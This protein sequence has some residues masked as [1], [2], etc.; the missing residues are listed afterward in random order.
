MFLGLPL[1]VAR[2]ISVVRTL[3]Y[4]VAFRRGTSDKGV[5]EHSFENDIFLSGVP[6]YQPRNGDVVLDVGAHL[7]DFS[8]LVAREIGSGRV[9]ALEPCDETFRLLKLNIRL[10]KITNIRPQK[11]ALAD[12]DGTCML[13]QAPDGQDWG[14]STVYDYAFHSEEVKCLTLKTFMDELNIDQV[15]FA[16]FNCEGAEFSVLLDADPEVLRRF[17]TML[18]LYHSD[19]A[20]NFVEE[21]AV[22]FES[23]LVR[24][25]TDCGFGVSIREKSSQRG[26]IVATRQE[27]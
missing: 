6:E 2:T 14:N 20:T 16:K 11:V 22:G 9:Y 19:F 4:I 25:L 8:M 21:E 17:S 5:L 10:N 3:G 15:D 1:S 27:I 23:D 26:W 12:H 18:V 24:H 7:G 13:Y